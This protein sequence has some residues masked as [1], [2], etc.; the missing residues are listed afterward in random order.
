M[1]NK[2]AT[3]IID[4]IENLVSAGLKER[5]IEPTPLAVEVAT[6]AVVTRILDRTRP[7]PPRVIEL[8]AKQRTPRKYEA[9]DIKRLERCYGHKKHRRGNA[10]MGG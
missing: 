10:A 9:L 7:T 5:G 3:P 8:P 1:S 4:Q 2:S 6:T